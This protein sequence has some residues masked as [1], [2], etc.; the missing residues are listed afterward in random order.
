MMAIENNDEDNDFLYFGELSIYDGQTMCG[1]GIR[2]WIKGD[3]KALLLG[4]FKNGS[5]TGRGRNIFENSSVLYEGDFYNYKQH[6][7]GMIVFPDGDVYI[8]GFKNG[9]REGNGE[10]RYGNGR[11]Y[12]GEWKDGKPHG[13][14][15]MRF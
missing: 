6:G 9:K 3:S 13:K 7:N 10:C 12:K 1:K 8:G 15:L 14:G 11:I 2:A 4:W 5:F